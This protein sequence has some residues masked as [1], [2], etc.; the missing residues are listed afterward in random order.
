MITKAE[1]IGSV[2][3]QVD[4]LN[5]NIYLSNESR[6]LPSNIASAPKDFIGREDYLKSLRQSHADGTRVH[7]LN[8]F[9][10]V[11][12]TALALKFVEEIK[13]DY[14]AHIFLNLQGTG[15]KPLTSTDAL[16]QIL[17]SFNPNIPP[18]TP[19]DELERLYVSLLNQHR[20]LLLLDN[21]KERSQVEHFNKSRNDCLL[22]TSRESF[23]LTGGN[24]LKI[25]PMLAT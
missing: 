8:G 7:I 2:I 1:K 5:Q 6:A 3:G 23:L 17:H 25:K 14:D 11:G 4:N 21:A 16:L 24:P 9:G 10:G 13:N 15:N 20:I 19:A 18:A 12:K 22:V